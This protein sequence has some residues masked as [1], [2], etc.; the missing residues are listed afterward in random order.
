MTDDLE[1]GEHRPRHSAA[2]QNVVNTAILPRII[3]DEP[4]TATG[5][6]GVPGNR[7][8]QRPIDAAGAARVRVD[9]VPVMTPDPVHG[10]APAVQPPV[11]P[12]PVGPAPVAPAPVGPAPVTPAAEP[13]TAEPFAAEPAPVAEPFGAPPVAP[14]SAAPAPAG[15]ARPAAPAAPGEDATAAA[16]EPTGAEIIW[17]AEH[18]EDEPAPEPA[19]DA[20]TTAAIEPPASAEPAGRGWFDPALPVPPGPAGTPGQLAET[21]RFEPPPPLAG[22]P[23][24]PV[25]EP[26]PPGPA[27][28]AAPAATPVPPAPAPFAVPAGPATPSQLP[29]GVFVSA[30]ALAGPPDPGDRPDPGVPADPS[31]PPALA[32]PPGPGLPAGQPGTVPAAQAAPAA[33]HVTAVPVDAEATALIPKIPPA[34][35]ADA[36]A[37]IRKVDVRP[38]DAA[39]LRVAAPTNPTKDDN[40][41]ADGADSALHGVK[42]VPLRPIRTEGGYRSV[43]SDLTRT[44]PGSVIRTTIRGVGELCITLGLILLLFAA[45]EV[46]GKTAAVNAHQNDLNKQLAQDWGGRAPSVAPSAPPSAGASA[47]P[48]PDGKA[49][50]RLYIPRLGKQWIVVQGVTPADIRFAPGHYPT[51]AMPGQVGNFSVAGHRTPAIFWDLDQVRDGDEIVVETKDTWYVYRMVQ[52]QIVTPTAVQVV[53]PVPNQ[54]GKKPTT[55]MLTITTCNPKWDNYERLVVHAA[56][57]PAQT[58]SRA[59]GRPAV[60]GG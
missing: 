39:S 25:I 34:G 53:A 1:P 22:P 31:G 27:P 9:P 60:L 41:E 18:V 12:A 7:G 28:F 48:P 52:S 20:E 3:D 45:Y 21:G 14:Q 13:F 19:P 58:R 49:I 35:D 32:G 26:L 4:P 57:D 42:V 36:T 23:A 17:A 51:S 40:A 29:G 5:A 16:Q 11:P 37:V 47:L 59:D 43:Y 38:T 15:S 50:A 2:D 24:A 46:W 44:T 56:L 8:P 30:A 6:T 55:A 33:A 54:P 10:P